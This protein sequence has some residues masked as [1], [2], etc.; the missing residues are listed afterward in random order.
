MLPELKGAEKA[1]ACVDVTELLDR[2]LIL[3]STVAAEALPQRHSHT[4][5]YNSHPTRTRSRFEI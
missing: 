1:P 5:P 2:S 4:T 3:L